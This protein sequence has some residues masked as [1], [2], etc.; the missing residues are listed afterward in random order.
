[1]H[2]SKTIVQRV[3]AT[4]FLFFHVVATSF[5][6]VSPTHYAG[7]FFHYL[8][9][10]R[11]KVALV[12]SG[13]GS[14]G[15][16]QV[17]VLEALEASKI[18]ID[19]IVGTSMGSIIGGLYSAGYTSSEL[20]SIARMQDWNRLMALSD[21]VSR[22][23]LFL[24]QKVSEEQ[25]FLVIRLNGLTP[26][27][28]S[29][30]TSGQ[31]L[32]TLLTRLVLNAP[33]RAVR[34]FDDLKVPFRAVATDMVSGKR[35]VMW[36]GDLAQAMRASS[37]VPVMFSPI[38]TDT[39]QLVDGG[40]VSNV[41]VDVA[42]NLGADIVIAVDATSPLRSEASIETPWDA[43]DQ[44]TSIMM[45][46][47][48]KLQLEKAD[49]VIRPNMEG[50]LASDFTKLDSIVFEGKVATLDQ[51]SRIDS[52]YKFRELASTSPQMNSV[53]E[54]V[55]SQTDDY[56]VSTH[57]YYASSLLLISK[58]EFSGNASIPDSSLAV[59]FSD[60]ISHYVTPVQ[61]NE[62]C[63]KLIRIYRERDFGMARL[64]S[65]TYDS[66]NAILNLQIG[67]GGIS[68]ISCH[69]NEVA[70][71]FLIEREFP[72]DPSE[73]FLT[74]RAIE[75]L[76]N[77]YSTGL[78]SQVLLSTR[79]TPAADLTIEVSEKS[80][81]LV[82]LGLRVDN[83]RNG[84]L[85]SSIS[86]EDILGSGT[87]AT[88]S[89]SGGLR[90]RLA[91]ANIGTTRILN[92]DITYDLRAFTGFRDAYAYS[93]EPLVGDGSQWNIYSTGEYRIIRY[94]FDFSIGTLLERFGLVDGTLEYGWDRLKPLQTYPDSY[95]D[96]IVSIRVGSNVDTRDNAG[97][98]ATGIFSNIYFQTSVRGL[99]S[100]VSF[101]K[102]FFDY[103]T[104]HSLFS[105]VTFG[106]HYEFGFGDASLPFSR[107]FSLGG[108]DLFY[109]LRD[110]ALIGRQIFL[111]SWELRLRSPFKIFFDTFVSGRFDIGDVWAQQQN[112]ILRTLKQ[113]I[114]GSLGFDTPIGPV[115]FSAGK[116][117]N[118][119]KNA[120]IQTIST[121]WTF[122]F[123]IGVTIPEV[124]ASR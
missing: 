41:P 114:G 83:E 92:T 2:A 5:G 124:A 25:S 58:I 50:H 80:S 111:A 107:Q 6:Q 60:I 14:R 95:L 12:L 21:A 22:S 31:R 45:Q 40:L 99:N 72:L 53:D 119:G 76:D 118:P 89:F 16:S 56:T 48:S 57:P 46:L 7:R 3:F 115:E 4:I 11:P 47:S 32:I 116:A 20:D 97:F 105:L 113:G 100:G 36:T 30:L 112:V 71:S 51:I 68:K 55:G 123:R 42:R 43:L 94:G 104:F 37:S 88:L 65:V 64:D 38:S 79:F 9:A 17:G 62:S 24:Q 8:E 49:V 26:I 28:P 103:A 52:I 78:F 61:I 121:P 93:E 82:R 63:E 59:A 18:P 13:G 15:I 19:M 77:I 106:Q 109:G 87:Q 73:I 34:S 69:G 27:L 90:N 75:G 110:D 44:A 122:Y 35:V 33:Y 39:L 29:A 1:M 81:R 67:E 108:Q 54:K 91:E 102:I 10:N 98:P 23:E 85:Y 84:Q 70:R 117:F 120:K 86:D 101:T 96:R 74:T 66:A